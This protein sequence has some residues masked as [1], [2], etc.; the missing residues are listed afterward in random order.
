[1][2]CRL[3]IV[4]YMKEKREMGIKQN[5]RP[6]NWHLLFPPGKQETRIYLRMALQCF[7]F[8]FVFSLV[9][10]TSFSGMTSNLFLILVIPRKP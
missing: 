6:P 10:M 4:V 1:M 7:G 2:P 8:P 9:F 3:Y 5:S